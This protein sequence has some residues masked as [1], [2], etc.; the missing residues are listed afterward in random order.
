MGARPSASVPPYDGNGSEP[1]VCAPCLPPA[2]VQP[3]SNDRHAAALDS[4][5]DLN[6]HYTLAE[7]QLQ[8]LTRQLPWGYLLLCASTTAL[9]LIFHG[10][11]PALLT[12]LIPLL[13]V[14]IALSRAIYWFSASGQNE[15]GEAGAIRQLRR[16]TWLAPVVGGV[17]ELWALSLS[18]FSSHPHHAYV[19]VFSGLSLLGILFCLMHVPRAAV[20]ITLSVL[21]PLI[22]NGLW[23]RDLTQIAMTINIVLIAALVLRMMFDSHRT[24]VA[25][26]RSRRALATERQEAERLNRENLRLAHT[27]LLTGLPNR[28]SFLARLESL[29]EERERDNRAPLCI[30]KLDLDSL[31]PVNDAYGHE[32]GDR[33]LTE[34]GRRLMEYQHKGVFVARLG[35]DE[36]GVICD[37]SQTEGEHM[38]RQITTRLTQPVNLDDIQLRIG[39]SGGI[40][41]YPDH[42]T[43]ANDLFARSAHALYH[44]KTNRRGECAVFNATH[45]VQVRDAQRIENLLHTADLA[46]ELTVQFQPIYDCRSMTVSS[47]EALARWH[48]PLMGD[49]PADKLIAAAERSGRIQQVT[50][51][52]FEK[53]LAALATLPSTIDL[54][55][56]LSSEDIASHGTMR[57]LISMVLAT[58][59]PPK[60]FIFEVTETSLGR[61]LDLARDVLGRLRVLGM[62]VALDDFGTGYSTL[63]TLQDLPLDIVKVDKS[64][65]RGLD[66]PSGKQITGAIRNLAQSLGLECTIEG[67]ENAA[68]LSEAIA[69]G[70]RYAQGYKL[71]QPMTLEALLSS[72]PGTLG[73]PVPGTLARA[74]R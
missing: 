42:G 22:V 35:G 47:V 20:A 69:M 32:A 4:A 13:I 48:S 72:L 66:S 54:S 5:P 74:I 30:A 68:Q 61:D 23:H 50:L 28:R 19:L 43:S 11:A 6:G 39:C 33:V 37:R 71:G 12:Y 14:G 26:I 64:F 70:Y 58:R 27:D 3:D 29:I 31:Q 25:L 55:F 24:F 40:A 59:Q 18:A 16:I 57:E 73:A 41:V 44:V 49:I 51:H 45:E 38:L 7:A 52:L 10:S 46:R 15:Q 63:A 21:V 8:H 62:R 2:P 1:M 53:A 36:F 60:R 34:A 56:N 67:V 9:A 17:S 65:A